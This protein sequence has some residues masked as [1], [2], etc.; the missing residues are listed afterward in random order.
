MRCDIS[1]VL[2][3]TSSKKSSSPRSVGSW[4][5]KY[6]YSSLACADRVKSH[7]SKPTAEG[8]PDSP[9]RT[10]KLGSRA[11][12]LLAHLLWRGPDVEVG[13]DDLA[14]GSRSGHGGGGGGE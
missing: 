10:R 14:G 4:P 3:L 7:R 9:G 2:S 11:R 12:C 6:G 8:L 1:E 5:G 13:V